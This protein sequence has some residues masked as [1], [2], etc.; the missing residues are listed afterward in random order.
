[1]NQLLILMSPPAGQG[2]QG[3]IM[4]FL[5]LILLILIVSL[6]FIIPFKILKYEKSGILK[7]KEAGD[8]LSNKS[9]IDSSSFLLASN[10]LKFKCLIFS[11]ISMFISL[12]FIILISRHK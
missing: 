11:I 10:K 3:G 7:I 1:M 12:I 6:I 5:P 9:L 4:S 2:G 8:Q